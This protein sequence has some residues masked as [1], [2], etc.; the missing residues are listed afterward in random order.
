MYPFL[1]ALA[2]NLLPI[3]HLK[4]AKEN[5]TPQFILVPFF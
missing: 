4:N 5:H 2:L 3:N 1:I